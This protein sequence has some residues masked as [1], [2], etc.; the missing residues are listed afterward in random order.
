MNE[1]T[2]IVTT[3]CLFC[4]TDYLQN[5]L[6]RYR[7]GYAYMAVSLGNIST[8]IVFLLRGN[9]LQLKRICKRKYYRWKKRN[10]VPQAVVAAANAGTS[11]TQIEAVVTRSTTTTTTSLSGLGNE[12]Q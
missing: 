2:L 11:S 9:F 4:F 7:I 10:A 8:H 12:T 6:V 5:V 3:Y 1:C